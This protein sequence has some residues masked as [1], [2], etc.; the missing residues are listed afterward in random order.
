MYKVNIKSLLIWHTKKQVVER[1]LE[2]MIKD[3]K[4]M[5][6][7]FRNKNHNNRLETSKCTT[8]FNSTTKQRKEK[9]VDGVKNIY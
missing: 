8:F 4:N 5:Y 2:Y 9:S 1:N 3:K 6:R 7:C